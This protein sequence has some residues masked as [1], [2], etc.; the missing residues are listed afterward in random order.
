MHD[1]NK[2]AYRVLVLLGVLLVLLLS[3]VR[4][5]SPPASPP[6]NTAAVQAGA[7][8]ASYTALCS[9]CHGHAGEGS[10]YALP[11]DHAHLQAI[12]TDEI[13]R[14]IREG[15]PGTTMIAW[16]RTLSAAQIEELAVFI[17]EMQPTMSEA[18]GE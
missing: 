4:C 18:S 1:R 17:A 15:V 9:S 12:G 14:L 2:R 6:A 11:F 5:A 8:P 10:D 13:S 3:V 7:V 16:N